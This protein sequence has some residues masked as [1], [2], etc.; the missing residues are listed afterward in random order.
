MSLFCTKK[1][2]DHAKVRAVGV[3]LMLDMMRCIMGKL[4]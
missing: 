4:L 3:F 1:A 2:A